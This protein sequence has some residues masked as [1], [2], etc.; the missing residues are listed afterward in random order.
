[1]NTTK[2]RPLT[3]ITK[4]LT[5]TNLRK[6]F[7]TP[8]SKKA[9]V[10]FLA[11]LLGIVFSFVTQ[12]LNTNHLSGP[13]E[14]GVVTASLAI[15]TFIYMFF[16]FGI[17][18]SG[19][20]LLTQCKTEL[21][22]RKMYGT[23]LVFVFFISVFISLMVTICST[24]IPFIYSSE[25]LRQVMAFAGLLAWVYPLQFFIQET[26]SGSGKIYEL[27]LYTVLSKFLY[28]ASLGLA[29]L[30]GNVNSTLSLLLNLGAMGLSGLWVLYLHKPIFEGWKF[31]IP[32]I[33][34]EVREYGW[35][36]YI[37]R[38]ISSPAFNLSSVLI[39]YFNPMASSAFF[40]VGSSLYAPM[41]MASQSIS[42]S[43][44]KNF[45]QQNKLKKRLLFI[46]ASVLIFMGVAI[47]FGA[48]ILIHL[49]ANER[50]IPVIPLMLPLV[51]AGFFQGLYQPF[52]YFVL[53]QGKGVWTRQISIA[54]T[55]FDIVSTVVL[56]SMYG[57]IGACWQAVASR[58]FWA[59]MMYYNYNR[60]VR[61]L[62]SQIER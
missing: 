59:G 43:L 23:L 2:I 18:T 45:S 60:T 32:A 46:N 42:S 40:A 8:E 56:V 14:Y 53:S 54:G 5:I 58:V 62:V 38:A 11:Q 1:M 44:Y 39:P 61:S 31:N 15:F 49:V 21:D 22:T 52:N 24:F 17:F 9:I 34:K 10:L 33:K 3:A 51:L 36:I 16:E 19:A 20:R 30:L 27:S 35:H 25:Q 12:K 57:L 55:V 41:S 26:A 6:L 37:A 13:Q 50:Y 29:I 47:Y 28:T 7:S 4:K 48:P